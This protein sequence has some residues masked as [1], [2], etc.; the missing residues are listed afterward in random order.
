MG[1]YDESEVCELI[2]TYLLNQLQVVITK[3]NVGLYRDS[4]LAIFKN[5]PGN[6]EEKRK[7]ELLKISK[8]NGVTTTVKVNVKQPPFLT[9]IL[10]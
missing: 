8:S 6:K 4:R 5:M 2:G 9:S 1:Y 3:E 10:I 7:K